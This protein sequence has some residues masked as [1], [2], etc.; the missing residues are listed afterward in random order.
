MDSSFPVFNFVCG[1]GVVSSYLGCGIVHI[2]RGFHSVP[3]QVTALRGRD[4]GDPVFD[5]PMLHPRLI[6]DY[7][8]VA[9]QFALDWGLRL[10]WRGS[11]RLIGDCREVASQSALDWGLRLMWRGSPRLIGDCREVASQSALDWGLRL[12]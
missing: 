5:S 8:E 9:S 3:A 2:R 7:R 4:W 11:P 6:G 12:M 10:M 1:G